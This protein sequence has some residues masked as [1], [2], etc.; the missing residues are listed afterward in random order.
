MIFCLFAFLLAAT[1]VQ[2]ATEA[3]TFGGR[4]KVKEMDYVTTT[5]M[6]EFLNKSEKYTITP[7]NDKHLAFEVYLP[8]GWIPLDNEAEKQK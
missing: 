8:V 7:L 2:A 1:P 5:T 4:E 3:K 6:E